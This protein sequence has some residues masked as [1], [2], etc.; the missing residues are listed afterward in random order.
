MKSICKKEEDCFA[1]YHYGLV[2]V[3]GP[4]VGEPCPSIMI[5]TIW[6][7]MKNAYSHHIREAREV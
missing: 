4:G 7:P 1:L 3:C 2:Q 6:Q 5:T